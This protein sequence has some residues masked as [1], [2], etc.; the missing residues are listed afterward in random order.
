LFIN[1]TKSSFFVEYWS[2]FKVFIKSD[3]YEK[4]KWFSSIFFGLMILI[5]FGF[6]FHADPSNLN[7]S[8]VV[9]E[10]FF[11]LLF[12]LQ[13]NL[14]R[15]LESEL[16]DR[17]LDIVK[18]YSRH[19]STIYLAKFSATCV[20]N[21]LVVIPIV[22]CASVV[23]LDAANYFQIIF[24]DIIYIFFQIIVGVSA[25]GSLLS[26]S[27]NESSGK[28]VLFPILFYPLCLPLFIIG[29]QNV[30][31]LL[32]GNPLDSSWQ[33]TLWSI[34]LIYFMLGLLLFDML[35]EN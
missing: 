22:M 1:K 25:L 27:V 2:L 35:L 33:I 12:I 15:S 32:N 20:L 26:L 34:D 17:A 23:F 30:L 4:E 3:K 6:I 31:L 8:V 7:Q 16:K 10:I 21:T 28:E 13:I 14:S 11:V 19:Y 29:M 24:W 18:V 5:L 9:A